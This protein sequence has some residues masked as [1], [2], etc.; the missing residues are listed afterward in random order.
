MPNRTCRHCG[1]EKSEKDFYVHGGYAEHVCK[2]C[3]VALQNV[4]ASDS[5]KQFF[6]RAVSSLRHSRRKQGVVF[7]IDVD[8]LLLAYEQQD[9]LCALSGVLMTTHRDGTGRRDTNASIDRVSSELPYV[10]NNVQLVCWA[11]NKMKSTLP[12]AEFWF[13]CEN[14][15]R[16]SNQKND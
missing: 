3:R 10:P 14:V 15:S 2:S 7:E 11:V 6:Q 1:E 4:N 12:Q 9:G 8:D 13:W 16:W 5:R